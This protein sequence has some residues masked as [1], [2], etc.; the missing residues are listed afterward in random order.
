MPEFVYLM[1]NDDLYRLGCTSNLET[2]ASKMKPG[3]IIAFSQSEDPKSFMARLLRL[4]KKKRIPDTS[5]FRLSEL[6]VEN[7]R[8]HLK[9]KSNLPKNLSDELTIGLNGSLLFAIIIFFISFFINKMFIFSFFLSILF[10][11]IPMWSL[12]ILGSFG[13]YDIDDLSLFSTVSN[14]LKGFLIAISMLSVAYI[15]YIFSRSSI[16]F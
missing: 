14:R 10:S 9:G 16:A 4:Y 15:L 1:K 3:K 2:E 7:C 13:G 6:E 5:Y 8:N 11:S 12:A